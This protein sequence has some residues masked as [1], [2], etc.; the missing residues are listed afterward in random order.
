[1]KNAE[2]G[3]NVPDDLKYNDNHQWIK[4]ID[5]ITGI[6]GITDF[7]QNNLGEITFI[8]FINNIANCEVNEKEKIAIIE[9]IKES[10]DI[11]SIVS[12]KIIDIN[13]NLEDSPEIVNNDPYGEGWIFKIEVEDIDNID[14]LMDPDE[15]LEIIMPEDFLD[16]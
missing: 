10:L 9:S 8:E 14:D 15:Y 4:M 5:D 11:Y 16:I 1:M 3:M 6:C 13:R 12:G 2:K 7:S